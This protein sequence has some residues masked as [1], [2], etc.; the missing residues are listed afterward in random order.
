VNI[1][2]FKIC[3]PPPAPAITKLGSAGKPNNKTIDIQ[4][5]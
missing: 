1:N 3:P 5:K 4:V 2:S